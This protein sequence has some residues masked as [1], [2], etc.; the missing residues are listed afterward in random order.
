MVGAAAAHHAAG[1]GARTVLV[2]RADPGRATDAGAGIVAPRTNTRDSI[3]WR[4]LAVAA[5]DAYPDLIDS[6]D[7]ETGYARAGLLIVA[8]DPS[9]LAQLE[10]VRDAVAGRPGLGELAP[11][12]ALDRYPLLTVAPLAAMVDEGAARLDGRLL[13]A[14]LT[15]AAVGRGAEVVDGD[16]ATLTEVG[17]EVIVVAGGA[18]SPRFE[19]ELGASIPVEPQKGQ[20]LHLELPDRPDSAA[21]PMVEALTDQY[22]VA[23]PGGR[24]VVG[25]TRETGSGF[26]VRPTAAGT[27]HVLD[28]ALRV[29]PGLGDARIVE[30]RV[31]LRPLTADLMPV[32]GR[33]PGRPDVVVA[34][35]HGPTGLT[36]GPYSGRL[37]VDVAL[38]RPIP[39]DLAPFAF[40][41]WG[42]G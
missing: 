21:W 22:Q 17:A 38:D 9:E 2:D 36:L 3:A 27:K 37:A 15:E 14:A 18:W 24:V 16:V 11:E 32:I 31:G 7:G 4:E 10:D 8:V 34:T 40:D 20:I 13:A 23:W 42:R 33:V 30:T 5:A 26:D 39:H 41:R 29:A 1:L 19:E 25:A 28:E 35:G 6:L 12:A